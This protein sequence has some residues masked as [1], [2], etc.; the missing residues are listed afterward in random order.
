LTGIPLGRYHLLP[1]SE[2]D[3]SLVHVCYHK[4]DK[5]LLPSAKQFRRPDAGSNPQAAKVN[6]DS[7]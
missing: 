3:F 7:N 4:N 6:P 5:Q 2:A 1:G